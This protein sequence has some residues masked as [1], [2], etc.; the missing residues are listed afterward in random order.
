MP[1]YQITV[2][3]PDNSQGVHQ[4][5]YEDGFVAAER[6]KAAFPEAKRVSAVP[7]KRKC[8]Q[9]AAQPPMQASPFEGARA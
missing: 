4:G 9:A 1:A 2:I 5:I 3:M 6:F 7:L 8:S